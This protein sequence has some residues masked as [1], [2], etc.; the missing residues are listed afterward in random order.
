M[1]TINDVMQIWV[2]RDAHS[3]EVA[4]AGDC[5]LGVNDIKGSPLVS[6]YIGRTT[7]LRYNCIVLLGPTYALDVLKV[8]GGY[9]P[10]TL[11]NPY[12]SPTPIPIRMLSENHLAVI[13]N[14]VHGQT[15]QSLHYIDKP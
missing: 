15:S 13:D 8:H 11:V 5:L 12:T 1:F 2:L 9:H 4:L 3:Y 14:R 7:D 10:N 6:A